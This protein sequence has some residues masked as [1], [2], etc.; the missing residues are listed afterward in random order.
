[1][2]RWRLA[3]TGTPWPPPATIGSV[4]LWN[5]TDPAHAGP[6]GPAPDRA[7]PT[8]WQSVAFSPDGHTL[9]SGSDDRHASGCGTSPARPTRHPLGQPLTGH[10]D[11]VRSV[12]FSPD[13]HTLASGSDDRTVRLWNLTNPAHPTPLGQPLP[14]HTD[15]VES[16]AFSPDGHTLASAQRRS[17]ASGCGT[18]PTRP[19]PARWA[20]P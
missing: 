3:R 18:S 14:G 16:V 11:A 7:T 8:P 13:G 17:T 4:R 19:T 12:A 15:G 2:D 5:L 20:S 6:L 10:T 9:A 1:M